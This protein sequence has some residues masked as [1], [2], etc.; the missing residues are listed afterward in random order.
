MG[1]ALPGVGRCDQTAISSKKYALKIPD[2]RL[3]P[4]KTVS[5]STNKIS[6]VFKT[7]IQIVSEAADDKL[8]D[9]EVSTF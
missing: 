4:K 1:V 3:K 5:A 6:S 8:E 9:W 2:H 7:N